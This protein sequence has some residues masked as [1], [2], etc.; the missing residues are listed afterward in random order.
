METGKNM[1]FFSPLR[2]KS[3]LR[4]VAKGLEELFYPSHA[5]CL[6]CRSMIGQTREW[7]CPE[8]AKKLRE[9]WRGNHVAAANWPLFRV[10]HA[11]RY[12][13]PAAEMVLALKYRGAR[14]LAASMARDMA[15][16]YYA[17]MLSEAPL[18]VAAPMHRARLRQRGYNQAEILART[19]CWELGLEYGQVLRKIRSTPRQTRL[20]AQER[21]KNLT[22]SITA[23]REARG[24]TILLIDD[25]FTT[26][27]TAR[28][29]AEAL[30]AAGAKRVYALT[31]AVAGRSE[32]TPSAFADAD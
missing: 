4:R 30:L 20:S 23:T 6:C 7:I 24:R 2:G 11:Y 22:G 5:M 3:V 9:N 8:C 26:G 27:T 29:C 15:V 1:R 28:T 32:N 10:A 19:L 31:Y 16:A 13:G 21:E 17:L 25:V 12:Q 18:V 14:V